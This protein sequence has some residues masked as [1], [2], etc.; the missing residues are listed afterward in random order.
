MEQPKK[1]K[2]INIDKLSEICEQYIKFIDNDEEYSEDNDN[3]HYIFECA[4]ETMYG[5]NV[6]DWIN[7][8][9]D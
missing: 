2:E 7:S 9:R 5:E 1:L 4:M 8:R 3:D 6:W